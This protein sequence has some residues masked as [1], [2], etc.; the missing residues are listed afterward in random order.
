MAASP[1]AASILRDAAKWPLLR[2]RSIHVEK[3]KSAGIQGGFIDAVEHM[4]ALLAE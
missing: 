2:M 4:N 1:C 3:V